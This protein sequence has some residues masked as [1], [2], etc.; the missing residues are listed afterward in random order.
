MAS[1]WVGGFVRVAAQRTDQM[2]GPPGRVTGD[3]RL[4]DDK[5]FSPGSLLEVGDREQEVRDLG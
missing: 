2:A 1:S 3:S 5:K 4:S